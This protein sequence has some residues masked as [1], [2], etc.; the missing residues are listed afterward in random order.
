M[1]PPWHRPFESHPKR[2]QLFHVQDRDHDGPCCASQ[3]QKHHTCR[4]LARPSLRSPWE[5]AYRFRPRCIQYSHRTWQQLQRIQAQLQST[6]LRQ[7][8]RRRLLLCTEHSRPC[9]GHWCLD[10][11]HKRWYHSECLRGLAGL[12]HWWEPC[13]HHAPCGCHSLVT[14]ISKWSF[15]RIGQTSD[16]PMKWRTFSGYLSLL[17]QQPREQPGM[18]VAA[19]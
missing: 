16:I 15:V 8:P 6:S 10:E 7:F 19:S 2:S 14:G 1:N 12:V 11:W 18:V 3:P 13:G 4:F 9:C 17:P 5:L